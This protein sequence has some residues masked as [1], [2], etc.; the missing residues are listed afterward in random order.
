VELLLRI[1]PF[2]SELKTNRYV[3]DLDLKRNAERFIEYLINAQDEGEFDFVIRA[4]EKIPIDLKII[5][6]S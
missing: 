6:R 3:K 2:W 4:G 1:L 5:S